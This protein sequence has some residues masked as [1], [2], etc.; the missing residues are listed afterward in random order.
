MGETL[1]IKVDRIRGRCERGMCDTIRHA[2]A[3]GLLDAELDAALVALAKTLARSVDACAA[4]GDHFKLTRASAELREALAA[5]RL[6]PASRARGEGDPL[7]S[8]LAE[9]SSSAPEMGDAE[10]D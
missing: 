7:E 5:L 9:L 8:L 1:P 2:K 3:A 4:N 10:E 6:D